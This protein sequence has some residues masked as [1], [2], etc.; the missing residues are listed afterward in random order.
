M[1]RHGA[2]G[3]CLKLRVDR[4]VDARVEIRVEIISLKFFRELARRRVDKIRSDG[5]LVL[6]RR[7]ELCFDIARKLDYRLVREAKLVHSTEYP[8]SAR[9]CVLGIFVGREL[10][11]IFYHRRDRCGLRQVKILQLF[12]E[13]CTGRLLDTVDAA[14]SVLAEIYLVAVDGKNILLGH[15]VFERDRQES[16]GKLSAEGSFRGEER[17]LYELLRDRRAALL[18]LSPADV[19]ERSSHDS[20]RVEPRMLKEPLVLGGD[21][22]VTEMSGYLFE[23]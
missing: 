3:G 16:F 4:R 8:I 20:T 22:R 23:F 13:I 19:R 12:T 18:Y 15:F 11:R 1:F 2:F 10:V 17:V 7:C 14:R 5:T 21:D 9:L 6:F